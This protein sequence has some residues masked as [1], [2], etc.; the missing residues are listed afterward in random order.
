MSKMPLWRLLYS[1]SKLSADEQGKIQDKLTDV[2]FTCGSPIEDLGDDLPVYT[3]SLNCY[4]PVEKLYYSGGYEAICVYCGST[5]N[6]N[7]QEEC[8]HLPQCADCSE[9]EKIKK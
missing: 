8:S 2:S 4:E 5:D 6:L 1:C 7:D 3:R 9:I